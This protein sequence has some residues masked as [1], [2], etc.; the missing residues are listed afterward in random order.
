MVVDA[1]VLVSFAP[2]QL[3]LLLIV[4]KAAIYTEN[5]NKEPELLHEMFTL[6]CSSLTY[7]LPHTCRNRFLSFPLINQFNDK[8]SSEFIDLSIN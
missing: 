1:G 2:F 7:L 4:F 5:S 6:D 3:R 8:L